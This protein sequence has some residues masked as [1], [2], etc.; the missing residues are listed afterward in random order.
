MRVGHEIR[1]TGKKKK[2]SSPAGALPASHR[3]FFFF[4]E[5]YWSFF[6]TFHAAVCVCVRWK[7]FFLVGKKNISIEIKVFRRLN[8]ILRWTRNDDSVIIAYSTT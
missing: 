1:R 2:K 4:H 6:P 3:R 5:F 8:V 7:S